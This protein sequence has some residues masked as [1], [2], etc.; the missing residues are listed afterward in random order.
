VRVHGRY[1]GVD[2]KTHD[3]PP[4]ADVGECNLPKSFPHCPLDHFVFC[5][6]EKQIECQVS[7]FFYFN[8]LSYFPVTTLKVRA[9]VKKAKHS[10]PDLI[11]REAC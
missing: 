7:F 8:M 9:W 4:L 2:S 3:V 5:S 6:F 1:V 11:G 10:R